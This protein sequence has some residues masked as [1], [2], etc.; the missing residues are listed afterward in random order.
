MGRDKALVPL[1]GKPMI[2]HVYERVKSLTHDVIVTTNRVLEYKFLG[3]PLYQDEVVGRGALGGLHTALRAAKSP[4]VAVVA[5]D[6]PF[7]NPELISAAYTRLVNQDLDAV[8][9]QTEY[10]FEPLHAV[11]RRHTCIQAVKWALDSGEWKVISWV[12]KVKTSYIE[13][14]EIKDYDPEEIAF[15]NVNTEEDLRKAEEYLLSRKS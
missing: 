2:V 9:P 6:M 14:Q 11:Y 15:W 1:L 10:G 7:A 13:P 12:K 4:I 8:I 3:L 5:C